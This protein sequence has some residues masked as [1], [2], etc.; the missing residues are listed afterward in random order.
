MPFEA[1]REV[2]VRA[3]VTLSCTSDNVQGPTWHRGLKVYVWACVQSSL[4]LISLGPIT[5]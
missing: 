4:K 3:C 1:A 2:K 5:A